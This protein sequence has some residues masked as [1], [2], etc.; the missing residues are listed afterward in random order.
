MALLIV[1]CASRVLKYDKDKAEQLQHIKEFDQT[2]KIVTSEEGAESSP[3]TTVAPSDTKKSAKEKIKE[4]KSKKEKMAVESGRRQPELESDLGFQGRRPLQDPFR[5]GEKVAHSV[6][7]LKMKAGT[8]TMEV[9]PFAIVNGKKS[10]NFKV[11]IGTSA[12][13]SSF[14]AVDDFVTTLMD[15]TNLV[16]SVFTLHVKETAQIREARA[17]FDVEKGFATFWERK[18]TEKNGE[19]E[20]KIQWDIA[21]YSQNVYSSIFYLR[22]FQWTVG[23]EHAFRVANDGENLIFRAKAI[24]KEKIS[25]DVGEFDAIVIK[26]EIE[27]KGK[28]KPVGDIFLWLSD[29]DRKFILRI[30]SKIKIGTLVSE[31]SELDRGL[32]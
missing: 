8:L 19:E 20:K 15:Y 26:P 3:A 10:Y 1:A 29:D 18:V 25:T 23:Q 17:F 30:E 4:K 11:A 24:R 21:D 31:I 5:V 32:K 16:P 14:Y 28:F 13:F 22:V 6:T 27:L 2:V 12:L 9:K 7:Y